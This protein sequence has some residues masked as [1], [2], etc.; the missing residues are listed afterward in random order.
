MIFTGIPLPEAHR[1][2]GE[3]ADYQG[4]F[5][6]WFPGLFLVCQYTLGDFDSKKWAENS[7]A[8]KQSVSYSGFLAPSLIKLIF[9]NN[10]LLSAI[11]LEQLIGRE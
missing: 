6:V 5:F 11:W 1:V 2:F 4:L 3:P 7:S 9:L 8:L 10:I